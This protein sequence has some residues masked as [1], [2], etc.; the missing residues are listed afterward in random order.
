MAGKITAEDMAQLA[1]L[2]KFS[3]QALTQLF[4]VFIQFASANFEDDCL[5]K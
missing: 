3:A 1:D 4:I 2:S 5:N